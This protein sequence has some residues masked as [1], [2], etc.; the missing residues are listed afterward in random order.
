[1]SE[2]NF[3]E[4]MRARSPEDQ[5]AA[6]SAYAERHEPYVQA[7]REGGGHIWWTDDEEREELFLRRYQRPAAPAGMPEKSLAEITQE[8]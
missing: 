3:T 1:M 4:Y 7:I 6:F 8:G 2:N 5:R